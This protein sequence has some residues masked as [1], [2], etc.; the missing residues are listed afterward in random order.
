MNSIKSYL[1]SLGRGVRTTILALA[2]VFVSAGIAQASTTISTNISTGGTLTMTDKTAL[3]AIGQ[4]S[5]TMISV[6]SNAYFGGTAT[7]SFSSA[8]AL[9]L[10]AA[11][12][13]TTGSFSSTLNVTGST[14]L[15]SA[16][17]TWLSALTKASFG[18]TATS[19]FNSA[20]ALTL[21]GALSGTSGTF[22]TTLGVTGL[23]T[24]SGG[25]TTTQITF[26]SGDTIKNAAA[27]TTAIS[28][29]VTADANLELLNAQAATSTLTAA[30]VVTTATSSATKIRLLFNNQATTTSLNGNTVQ[31]V[32]LWGYGTSCLN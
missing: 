26:L 1:N 6:T 17:T 19:S 31:G 21:A 30:C 29:S 27:S 8:G 23:T 7:S 3:A 10:I 5:T 4:A 12:T 24:L 32:V 9:T 13:G 18:S 25:A 22:S 11:L 2:V 16:S 15:S 28:G 14:T 20:G